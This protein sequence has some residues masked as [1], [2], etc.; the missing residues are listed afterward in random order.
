[1]RAILR[2]E[3]KRSNRPV[4]LFVHN[5][6]THYTKTLFERLAKRWCMSVLFF[7]KGSEWYW[8]KEHGVSH[9]DFP[10][11]YLA[12]SRTPGVWVMPKLILELL[13]NRYD[14]CVKCIN[15]KFALAVTYVCAR[16]RGKPFILYTGIWTR[17][18]QGI[19]PIIFPF[20]RHI[21]RHADA[22]VVYGE[23]V[24]RYLVSEGVDDERIFTAPHAVENQLYSQ[25]PDAQELSRLRESLNI[26]PDARIFLYVGRLAM[27]K[28]VRFLL[29]AIA[30][31]DEQDFLLMLIG[32]GEERDGLMRL[33]SKLGVERRT[34]FLGYCPPDKIW[35][36]LASAWALVLPSISLKSGKELWGLVVNEAFNQGVP[37]IA[38]P[39]VGAVAGGLVRDGINGIV[40]PE[41]DAKALA[42]AFRLILKDPALRARLSENA[43]RS[44]ANW[45]QDRMANGFSAAI[46]S[47]AGR[48]VPDSA[49]QG[50]HE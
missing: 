11:E 5:F 6:C 28:G 25:T 43:R 48:L 49:G 26:A 50:R 14:V 46:S 38:T 1:M 34:R 36:H 24:R 35:I 32:T 13:F 2:T 12:D 23:H 27:I 17:L 30:D 31:I 19:H 44:I 7:S 4:V 20:L 22:V 9:G 45:T 39:A 40:V 42:E 21:Y 3:P 18:H 47:V 41:Q 8:L 15:G 10:H 33:S 37:V 16:L 29:E